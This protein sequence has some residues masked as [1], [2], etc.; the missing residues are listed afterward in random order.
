MPE[1]IY[2]EPDE[3]ITSVIDKLKALEQD[4]KKVTLV[5][6]KGAALLQSVVNLKLLKREG[7][8]LKKDLSLVTQDRIGRNLASQAGF[9]VYD[10]LNNPHPIIE[11]ARPQPRT[12]EI[13]ELDLTGK[14][15]DE[16]KAPGVAVH[17]Y[18]ESLPPVSNVVENEPEQNY[19]EEEKTKSPAP[20]FLN[21]P[22]PVQQEEHEEQPMPEDKP[23]STVIW[24]REPEEGATISASSNS[25]GFSTGKSMKK[26]I[27]FAFVGIIL[28]VLGVLFYLFYPKAVVTLAVKT[29]SFEQPLE[30]T[31]DNNIQKADEARKAIPGEL[32]E[33]EQQGSKKFSATGKKEI[34]EKAKG[35]ITVSNDS[36]TA[37]TVASGTEFKSDSGQIFRSTANV[38]ILGATAS[39]DSHGNVVKTLGK[40]DVSV[41]AS[42]PG[43]QFNISPTNFTVIGHDMLTGRSTTAM[44]GGIS[45]QLTIVTQNDLN[46]AKSELS[47]ELYSAGHDDLKKKAGKS[48]IMDS[49][50]KDDAISFTADKNVNDQSDDFNITVKTKSSTIS[51]IEDDFRAMV[52]AA[53]GGLVPK[54]KEL[55]LS[56]SDE[57]SSSMTDV[58][59]AHGLLKIKGTVKTKLA[60]KIDQ[61][62]LKNSIKGKKSTEAEDIIKLNKAVDSVSVILAPS[63]WL[64]KVPNIDKNIK[65]DFQYK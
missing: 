21:R 46:N 7:D 31:I 55:I 29:D 60:P 37:Q 45:R 61:D 47:N 10:N 28:I 38:S 41:E 51:F 58:D 44:S 20:S 6:P 14:K 18:D 17:R 27:F 2:L 3:E 54:D 50:F 11:P 26:K 62:Q 9:T 36:G 35:T 12:E 23:I 64:K 15:Q 1:I 56:S 32:L 59:I 22:V 53:L 34:G 49:S 25:R 48:K 40:S 24:N 13:I 42:D 33:S 4:V 65:L 16:E 43:D 19:N 52:V 8:V 57:I 5:V 30:I 63:W 39:V